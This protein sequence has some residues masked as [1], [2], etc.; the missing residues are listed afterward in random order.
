[1]DSNAAQPR[2]KYLENDERR[3]RPA[4]EPQRLSS[5]TSP[6]QTRRRSSDTFPARQLAVGG[7]IRGQRRQRIVAAA[8]GRGSVRKAESRPAT[9]RDAARSLLVDEAANATQLRR[10]LRSLLKETELMA[11]AAALSDARAAADRSELAS[12][13]RSFSAPLLLEVGQ[14]RRRVSFW[15]GKKDTKTDGVATGTSAPLVG[16]TSFSQD[17]LRSAAGGGGSGG[18]SVARNA[19]KSRRAPVKAPTADVSAAVAE[20]SSKALARNWYRA[21]TGYSL[22]L[23]P[24]RTHFEPWKAVGTRGRGSR[25]AR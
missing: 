1:V 16:A 17:M 8:E 13:I 19:L 11:E 9:A 15:E 24:P 22:R 7:S 6:A 21:L 5:A 12:E 4:A 20:V 10:A 23:S 18:A 2:R 3:R 14:L 25:T